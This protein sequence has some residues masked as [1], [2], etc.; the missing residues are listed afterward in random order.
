MKV[1]K[2]EGDLKYDAPV[3]KCCYP[4]VAATEVAV[5]EEDDSDAPSAV[6]AEAGSHCGEALIENTRVTRK[7]KRSPANSAA[8]DTAPISVCD[9]EGEE[10]ENIDVTSTVDEDSVNAGEKITLGVHNDVHVSKCHQG[11]KSAVDD[12]SKCHQGTRCDVD[13]NKCHQETRC[14]VDVNK[15]H[16][17]TRCDVAPPAAE[18][19]DSNDELVLPC[20]VRTSKHNTEADGVAARRVYRNKKC[21]DID[22]NVNNFS[23]SNACNNPLNA[24]EDAGN[25]S[26]CVD[27]VNIKRCCTSGADDDMDCEVVAKDHTDNSLLQDDKDSHSQAES[28]IVVDDEDSQESSG[29]EG[30]A[31]QSN[32]ATSSNVSA[33]NTLMPRCSSEVDVEGDSEDENIDVG[34]DIPDSKNFAYPPVI[35]ADCLRTVEQQISKEDKVHDDVNGTDDQIMEWTQSKQNTETHTRSRKNSIETDEMNLVSD[36]SKHVTT[37]ESQLPKAAD[38]QSVCDM[39]HENLECDSANADAKCTISSGEASL[40]HNS[41]ADTEDELDSE[42]RGPRTPEGPAPS[43]PPCPHTP[44]TTPPTSPLPDCPPPSCCRPHSS[45]LPSIL[46]EERPS[47]TTLGTT[48]L[49]T[50]ATN[51]AYLDLP[52]GSPSAIKNSQSESNLKGEFASL[53]DGERQP[54][55]TL[56]ALESSQRPALNTLGNLDTKLPLTTLGSLDDASS[57]LAGKYSEEATGRRSAG[58]STPEPSNK[59]PLPVK[60]KLSILEYRKRK[61]VNS[62]SDASNS[63]SRNASALY[64]MSSCHSPVPPPQCN[65]LDADMPRIEPSYVPV[66]NE[67]AP[68]TVSESANFTSSRSSANNKVT[69]SFAAT[70]D[71]ASSTSYTSRHCPEASLEADDPLFSR[72]PSPTECPLA[73]ISSSTA[74]YLSALAGEKKASHSGLSS[75]TQIPP[76]VP[77]WEDME[78]GEISNEDDDDDEDL[79]PS[80]SPPSPPS[81]GTPPPLPPQAEDTYMSP[82]SPPSPQPSSR[83]SPT[84]SVKS[85]LTSPS[86]ISSPIKTDS[87]DQ[88]CYR[89]TLADRLQKEFGLIVSPE[90]STSVTGGPEAPLPPPPPLPPLPCEPPSTGAPPLPV[91]PPSFSSSTFP[92]TFKQQDGPTNFSEQR[93][94]MFSLPPRL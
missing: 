89:G 37:D 75:G 22:V 2:E 58:S 20:R 39:P 3:G 49:T 1:K 27:S 66:D 44:V 40:S 13:V 80:G 48:L 61:S 7:R 47:I 26:S 64:A 56:G 92:N 81:P 72:S 9:E 93:P 11:I 50:L 5:K 31:C 36:D 78:E 88:P 25:K 53:S 16:Q 59:I 19:D 70:D 67:P 94:Q 24:E 32:S 45:P 85:P 65:V 17:E 52:S 79:S 42:W 84:V 71:T 34:S 15:C 91:P 38:L 43:S 90:D 29:F 60:R 68:V 74:S 6:K 46:S 54:L 33:N 76:C 28:D 87:S 73:N 83:R 10:E 4:A 77:P 14:D 18:P 55:T 12:V 51:I 41:A 23:V 86:P 63:P 62:E 21:K 30:F 69:T 8:D 57:L 35:I 82:R